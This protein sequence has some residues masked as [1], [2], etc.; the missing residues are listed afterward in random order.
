VAECEEALG[1]SRRERRRRGGELLGGI[2]PDLVAGCA[3]SLSAGDVP[4]L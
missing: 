1:W 4:E 3:V 2:R